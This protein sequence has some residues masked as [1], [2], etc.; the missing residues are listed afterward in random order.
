MNL[1]KRTEMSRPSAGP[2]CDSYFQVGGSLDPLKPS[3][4]ERP[5]DHELYAELERGNLCYVLDTRQMGKSSLI[6]RVGRRLKASGAAVAFIDLTQFGQTLTIDQWY[7]AQ[8]EALGTEF[9]LQA[10]IADFIEGQDKLG[11]VDLWSRTIREVVLARL[12]NR[13]IVIVFDEIDIV[14]SLPFPTDEYFAAIRYLVNNRPNIP[15]LSRLTFCLLGVATPQ[16][17]IRGDEITP[18]NLGHRVELTDFSEHDAEKL[19]PGLHPNRRAAVKLLHRIMYWSD[20]HPYLTQS[21]CAAVARRIEANGGADVDKICDEVFFA[22]SARDQ[23]DN[24]RMV[25][26]RL[27]APGADPDKILGRYQTILNGDER[28]RRRRSADGRLQAQW[29]AGS[30]PGWFAPHL[31]AR[32]RR[33][34]IREQLTPDEVRRQEQGAKGPQPSV[35]A[36]RRWLRHLIAIF[37]N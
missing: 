35:V 20:G 31:C 36:R 27:F 24:L 13:R 14:R 3:Y 22:P 6:S 28:R 30:S 19:L 10:E 37:S 18:F 34:V 4:L 23:N 25:A 29:H 32:V 33:C 15:G 8:L 9:N 12:S 11:P 21:L 26:R 16:G 7:I 2:V 1:P 5:A 17:L